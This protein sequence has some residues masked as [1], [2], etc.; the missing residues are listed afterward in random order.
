MKKNCL[1][2]VPV[3]EDDAE[4]IFEMMQDKKYQEHY[5]E[6]LIPKNLNEAKNS[7]KKSIKEMEKKFAYNFI[8]KEGKTKIGVIDIYKIMQKDKR[9]SIGYGIKRD[10]WRKGYGTIACKLGANFIKTKLKLHSIEAT[11]E[12]NNKA[13]CR[14]LEKNGFRKIGVIEDYYLNKGKYV[15]RVLYWKILEEKKNGF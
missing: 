14:V 10:Y 2:L 12:P 13:S 6:R 4:F 8:L 7:V 5:L 15:N 3:S 1:K 11:A 9:C